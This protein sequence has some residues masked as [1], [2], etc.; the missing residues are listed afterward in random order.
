MPAQIMAKNNKGNNKPRVEYRNDRKDKRFDKDF[1]NGNDKK[2]AKYNKYGNRFDK[3]YAK[4]DKRNYNKYKSSRPDIIVVN[5][6]SRPLP[7]PPPPR[8]VVY[9]NDASCAIGVVA[10]AIGLAA[11]AAIVA[12]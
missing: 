3:K 7:P 4:K 6:P 9:R 10:G 5:R 1:R 11:L 2:F 8:K 12:N